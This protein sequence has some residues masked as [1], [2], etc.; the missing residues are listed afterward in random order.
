MHSK[1]SITHHQLRSGTCPW[2][3]NCLPKGGVS[4][5]NGLEGEQ[6]RAWCI[7]RM[8]RDLNDRDDNTRVITVLNL[9]EDPPGVDDTLVLLRSAMTDSRAPIWR[10][11]KVALARAGAKSR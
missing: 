10:V 9:A 4:P 1:C 8:A 11:A 5:Q 2:C 3:G 6:V 7:E